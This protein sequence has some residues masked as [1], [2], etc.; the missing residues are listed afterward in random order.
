MARLIPVTQQEEDLWVFIRDLAQ[1]AGERWADAVLLGGTMVRI[2]EVVAAEDGRKVT[3]PSS[4]LDIA[5]DPSVEL[6]APTPFRE[7]LR[8]MGLEPADP[9]PDQ[10]T[11]VRRNDVGD[12][13]IQ[14]DLVAGV[15]QERFTATSPKVELA[16]DHRVVVAPGADLA[17]SR[18]VT[19]DLDVTSVGRVSVRIPD[20]E[21]AIVMKL[22]NLRLDRPKQ[23]QD[24]RDFSTLM[25]LLENVDDLVDLL[26]KSRSG[27]WAVEALRLYFGPGGQARHLLVESG[28]APDRVLA[29]GSALLSR[30]PDGANKP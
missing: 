6:A 3:R 17:V 29:Q 19:V 28:A 15:E 27:S 11:F 1:A 22:C 8:T 4:D 10:V 23:A 20:I 16:T 13:L 7:V 14:V 2:H 21:S 5:L 18:S 30:F 9:E 25:D 12:V 24:L 26:G